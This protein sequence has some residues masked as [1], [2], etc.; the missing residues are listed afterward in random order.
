LGNCLATVVV[1]RWEGEFDDKKAAAF[2][3]PEEIRRELAAG[4]VALAE[5]A[6]EG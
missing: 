6:A 5:A 4:E 1:A 2:G 3:T